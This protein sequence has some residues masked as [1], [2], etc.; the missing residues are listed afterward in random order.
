[1]D[2]KIRTTAFDW[3]VKQTKIQGDIL[4]RT[5]LEGGFLLDGEKITLLGA[6]GIWKPK[7]M[8]YPLSI[9]AISKGA[10]S[11]AFTSKGLLKYKYRGEDPEHPDNK[12]LRALI[13]LQKPLIYFQSKVK[14]KYKATW[15]VYIVDDNEKDL[16]FTVALKDIA[17]SRKERETLV[18]EPEAKLV[19]PTKNDLRIAVADLDQFCAVCGT[20]HKE[21]LVQSNIRT[22]IGEEV[23]FNNPDDCISVCCMHHIAFKKGYIGLDT[24]NKIILNTNLSRSSQLYKQLKKYEGLRLYAANQLADWELIN[25]HRKINNI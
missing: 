3:L 21:F 10:Y 6:K 1:M 15:P 7:S 24:N 18:A 20:E 11:D 17:A 5:L 13:S 19:K 14:G 12:G 2:D 22:W 9:T 25:R 23:T 16:E 8:T 4:P